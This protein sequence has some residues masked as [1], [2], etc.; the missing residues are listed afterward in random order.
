VIVDKH[1]SL[2]ILEKTMASHPYISGAGNILHMIGQLRKNFP[3]IVTSETVKKFGLAPNN[4]SSVIN[5]LQFVG[6]LD[7]EGKRTEKGQKIL[8]ISNEKDF[9]AEFSKAVATAYSELFDLHGENAWKLDKDVLVNF[10]R[11]TDK[12][13]EAIGQ[14]QAAVFK[15]FSG[16]SG[17]SDPTETNG[18][19]KKSS[20]A[21]QPSKPK[22]TKSI[23]KKQGAKSDELTGSTAGQHFQ[24]NVGLTVRIEINLPAG[25]NQETYDS[26][27][28]SIKANLIDS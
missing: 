23:P 13:S 7:E 4:E 22:V 26:I 15:V 21:K 20:Q 8:L 16:L 5:A 6:F 11:T 1:L 24:K 10:F 28:K 2:V 18:M 3:T 25:G 9:Q 27:F 14:R 17:Y 19:P 12:T